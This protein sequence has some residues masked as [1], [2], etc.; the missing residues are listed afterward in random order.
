MNPFNSDKLI[1]SFI[2]DPKKFVDTLYSRVRKSF[3]GPEEL[4]SEFIPINDSELICLSSDELGS[5]CPLGIEKQQIK[6]NIYQLITTSGPKLLQVITSNPFIELGKMPYTD[7]KA[8]ADFESS[9]KSCL[10]GTFKSNQTYV[11][12]DEYTNNVLISAFLNYI[13]SQVPV[14]AGLFGML[15]I[16]SWGKYL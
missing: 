1:L 12:S 3:L 13:Y 11:E 14:Q 15:F 7:I 5:E 8:L 4:N 16:E 2:Q 9:M 10:Y 6:P